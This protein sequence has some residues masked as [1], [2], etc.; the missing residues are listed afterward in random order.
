M[1]GEHLHQLTLT[2]S[3]T[4]RKL[5]ADH[6]KTGNALLTQLRTDKID[7]NAFLHE[8]KVPGYESPRC[9]VG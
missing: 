4:I 9:R 7:F 8:R 2:R 3:K 1:K 5:Q 6:T